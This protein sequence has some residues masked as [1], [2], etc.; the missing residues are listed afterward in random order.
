MISS[1][2]PI[3]SDS[4]NGGF[5]FVISCSSNGIEEPHWSEL[6]EIVCMK[7]RK[8]NVKRKSELSTSASELKSSE[9]ADPNLLKCLQGEYE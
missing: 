9:I 8:Q 7:E 1:E 4:E 3:P 5:T 2:L 6:A